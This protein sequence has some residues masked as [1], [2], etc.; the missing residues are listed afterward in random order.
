MDGFGA[1]MEQGLN[2]GNG[3]LSLYEMAPTQRTEILDLLFN[4]STGAGLSIVRA[5]LGVGKFFPDY[6]NNAVNDYTIE[7]NSPG[8][9]TCTPTY[10]WDG[11]ANGMVWQLQQAK[12]RGVKTIYGNAFSAPAFMKDNNDVY[13]GG[14]LCGYVSCASGD[15]RAAY[16]NFLVKYIQSY[17]SSGITIDYINGVNEPTFAPSYQ[18]MLMDANQNAN[19]I[20]QYLGPAIANAGLSTKIICCDNLGYQEGANFQNVIM[21]DSTARS[22]EAIAGVHGYSGAVIAIPSVTAQGKHTWM[23]ENS[24]ISDFWNTSYSG[25]GN[26]GQWLSDLIYNELINGVSAYV[27]WMGAWAHSDNEDLIRLYNPTTYEVSK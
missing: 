22:Y 21:A 12:N 25:A 4:Q 16:A 13:N 26:G 10:Q 19:F 7:P 23:S 9:G 14:H 8:C 11:N 2:L 20:G 5:E 15:W 27:A 17:A 24:T 6:Q 3:F 18:S 1:A